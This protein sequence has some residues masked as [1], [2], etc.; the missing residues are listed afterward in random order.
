MKTPE[1]IHSFI[2]KAF[3]EQLLSVRHLTMDQ[4][5]DTKISKTQLI[6]SLRV[7]ELPSQEKKIMQ[8]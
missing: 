2:H 1:N 7:K 4:S 6:P 5:G 8:E 3:I